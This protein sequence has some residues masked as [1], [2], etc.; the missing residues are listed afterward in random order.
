MGFTEKLDFLMKITRTT[1]SQMALRLSLDASYISRL[2]TG[3]RLIPKNTEL[4]HL[5]SE[6]FERNLTDNTSIKIVS[7][8]MRAIPG[9]NLASSIVGWFTRDEEKAEEKTS[10]QVVRFLDS[11]SEFT[12][13]NTT[14][15]GAPAGLFQTTDE[16]ISVYY[17]VEGKRRAAI[18]FLSEVALCNKPQ[19]LLLHSSE[20][21]S[22]MLDDPTFRQQWG[23]LMFAVLNKGNRIK[24]IHVVD[25]GIDEMLESITSWM[26]LYMTGLIEPYYYPKKRDNIFKQTMFIAPETSAVI[27]HSVN[28]KTKGAANVL[29]R[30]KSAVTAYVGAYNE[31]LGLCRPLF[32]IF[33]GCNIQAF[34]DMM[35]EF[36]K[37]EANTMEK[38]SSLSFL[39]IPK[40]LLTK[41]LENTAEDEAQKILA[42]HAARVSD[43]KKL[44][45]TCSYT[46]V[47]SL[48]DIKSLFD[49]KV[50]ADMSILMKGGIIS[51]TPQNY[52]EHMQNIINLLKI[53][54]N[55]HAHIISKP[56]DDRYIV[57]C[58]E[59]RGV[60][61][62][63]TSQPP[64]V[65]ATDES[66]LTAAFWDFLKHTVGRNKYEHPDNEKTIERLQEYIAKV[67]AAVKEKGERRQ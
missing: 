25:R 38:T 40:T 21:M 55:Y 62:A 47:I 29:F 2:R 52:I 31:Y 9:E 48:P 3:K 58:R 64:V 59:D 50:K 42:V 30:D 39:T 43:F 24:I 51:Y 27:S 11:L 4:L 61:V 57:Y 44:L 22:W 67:K 53:N 26:P 19:T 12:P 35:A 36:E 32:K 28:D 23:M 18:L 54:E 10:G 14:L 15:K 34:L 17:G 56:L 60:I 13:K 41:F 65:L 6:Y 7:E 45:N 1:N 33:T 16:V 49:K 20:E 5:M 8:M 63:K 37:K 46:E 66:Q